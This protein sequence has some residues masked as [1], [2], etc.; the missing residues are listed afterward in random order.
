MIPCA[1]IKTA[2]ETAETVRT[3]LTKITP[4]SSP[5]ALANDGSWETR[6]AKKNATTEVAFSTM[7]TAQTLLLKL[8]KALK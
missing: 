7:E 1:S 4:H 6:H 3:S 5:L 2:N 8:K